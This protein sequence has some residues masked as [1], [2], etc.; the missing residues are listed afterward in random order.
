[1]V[2]LDA[3]QG[4][5]I[6]VLGYVM[7]LLMKA[8]GLWDMLLDVTG[9]SITVPSMMLVTQIFLIG[10][11]MILLATF[12]VEGRPNKQNMIWYVILTA[13]LVG[14]WIYLP[15][16]LPQELAAVMRVAQAALSMG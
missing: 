15:D 3:R 16:I 2:R 7:L 10:L 11:G 4:F 8:F 12:V 13:A 9:V 14:A 1:M 6:L 5:A